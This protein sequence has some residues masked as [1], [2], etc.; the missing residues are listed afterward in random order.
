MSIIGKNAA[1]RNRIIGV[2]FPTYTVNS[3]VKLKEKPE[4][5]VK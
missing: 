3:R 2:K 4:G 1:R 5:E